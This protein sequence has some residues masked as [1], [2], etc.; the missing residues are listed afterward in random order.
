MK[1]M[2]DLV[3]KITAQSSLKLLLPINLYKVFTK[4]ASSDSIKMFIS[5]LHFAV[6]TPHQLS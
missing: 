4:G 5:N 6:S 1:K 2:N 3:I